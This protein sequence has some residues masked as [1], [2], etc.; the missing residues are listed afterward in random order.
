MPSIVGPPNPT[1]YSEGMKSNHFSLRNLFWILAI[2]AF[3]VGWTVDRRRLEER[4]RKAEIALF[5]AECQAQTAKL[6][7]EALKFSQLQNER[8]RRA[9]LG[10]PE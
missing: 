9:A 7:L 4:C 2:A 8:Q 6:Q 10:I 1:R 3:L 5:H